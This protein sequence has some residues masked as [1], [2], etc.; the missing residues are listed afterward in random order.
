MVKR[1]YLPS[2]RSK[3]TFNGLV[4]ADGSVWCLADERAVARDPSLKLTEK[5]ILPPA[6]W[7]FW[8]AQTDP[9]AQ[10]SE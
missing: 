9:W 10:T 6:S 7:I 2:Q 1:V 4:W 5:K 3:G 8:S